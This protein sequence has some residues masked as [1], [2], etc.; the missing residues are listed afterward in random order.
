L[1]NITVGYLLF[2]GT[3]KNSLML[4]DIRNRISVTIEEQR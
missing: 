1:F 2:R 3:S 4:Q